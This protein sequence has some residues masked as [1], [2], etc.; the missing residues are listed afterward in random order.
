MESPVSQQLDTLVKLQNIDI[1]LREIL[2]IRG[3]LPEE[4][5]DLQ[6][7]IAGYK[8]RINKFKEETEALKDKISE[9]E[10]GIRNAH[11]LIKKYNE[12]QM[13]VR[14]NREFE[15]ITKEVELQHLEIKILEK[16]I[17][18]DNEAIVLK[19][20]KISSTEEIV[21]ERSKDLESKEAELKEI[22]KESEGDETKLLK[23]REKVYKQV[24]DRLKKAYD[25]I[26]S[27]A[28]NGLSVVDVKRNACGGCFNMVPP[29]RQAD[30]RDRKKII[31]CEHCGRILSNVQE[32][33]IEEVEKKPKRTKRATTKKAAAK[34]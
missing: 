18:E 15:A 34:K 30:V 10:N 25:R 23:S 8:T 20:D 31:V 27:N 16:R 5:A 6:D 9:Q 2:K 33:V 12:Q 19:E 28:R 29:Q 17:K 26:R 32:I 22:L 13:N 11:A 21:S 4:V 1:Q 7:E 14:N 3:A 24:D